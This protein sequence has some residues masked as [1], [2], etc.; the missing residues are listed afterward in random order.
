MNVQIRI[1][2]KMAEFEC[3]TGKRPNAIY[4]GVIEYQLLL[5]WLHSTQLI[6]ETIQEF[7]GSGV[8]LVALKNH[9]GIGIRC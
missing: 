3:N 8:Y 9:M 2:E 1:I 5:D 6:I 7:N 4:L